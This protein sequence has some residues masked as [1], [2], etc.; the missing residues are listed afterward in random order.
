MLAIGTTFKGK[1]RRKLQRDEIRPTERN[2]EFAKQKFRRWRRADR[3]GP[4]RIIRR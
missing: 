3:S 1:E 4:D 2:F